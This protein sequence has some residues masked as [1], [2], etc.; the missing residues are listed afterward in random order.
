MLVRYGR[1]D[2]KSDGSSTS[3]PRGS[4]RKDRFR[5]DRPIKRPNSKITLSRAVANSTPRLFVVSSGC[6]DRNGE[7]RL[8]DRRLQVST[9]YHDARNTPSVQTVTKASYSKP[10]F[11]CESDL[12]IK[13]VS[14]ERSL[15]RRASSSP[16][17]APVAAS[18]SKNRSCPRPETAP[19]R[20]SGE[21][22]RLRAVRG[23]LCGVGGS[24]AGTGFVATSPHLTARVYALESIPEMFR[25]VLADS[26]RAAFVR[27]WCPPSS[28]KS[29]PFPSEMQRRD[30]RYGHRQQILMQIRS[31]L[32]VS[33]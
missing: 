26:G 7:I 4:T 19:R 22:E 8:I 6:D 30:L 15:H 14:P 23:C 10:A 18:S 24:L 5:P 1:D 27:R 16:R 20:S 9:G 11:V 2:L 12:E 25:T 13:N 29:V 31:I 21:S 32:P 17:R 3:P 28:E 33:F